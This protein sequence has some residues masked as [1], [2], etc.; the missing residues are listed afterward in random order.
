MLSRS[1][2][3]QSIQDIL[4][5]LAFGL[6]DDITEEMK[7]TEIGIDSLD[8]VEILMAFEDAHD[9]ELDEDAVISATTVAELI[10]Y[11]EQ[12]IDASL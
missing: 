9:I 8:T 2:I 4:V 10:T 7:L 6:A 5:D 3:L 12:A 11:L 1:D